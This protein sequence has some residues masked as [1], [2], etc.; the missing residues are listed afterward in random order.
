MHLRQRCCAGT[1]VAT[2]SRPALGSSALPEKS[3]LKESPV[4]L[5]PSPLMEHQHPPRICTLARHCRIAV[6]AMGM[7]LAASG[8]LAQYGPA[9][10]RT[11]LE[12]RFSLGVGV[13]NDSTEWTYGYD[14]GISRVFLEGSLCIA[15]GW[16]A[17]ARAGG[18]NLV[19]N[20]IALYRDW[21]RDLSSDGYQAFASLGL[22]GL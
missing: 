20:D 5:A 6:V 18:A 9:Q 4:S 14:V 1:L 10:P 2:S 19:V 16:E 12:Q 17:F 13:R 15:D 3:I 11:N 8:A 7:L 21:P 22:R